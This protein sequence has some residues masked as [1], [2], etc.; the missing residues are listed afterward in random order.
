MHASPVSNSAT[1][2]SSKV[3]CG[4]TNGRDAR[5]VRS[6]M[7]YVLRAKHFKYNSYTKAEVVDHYIEMHNAAGPKE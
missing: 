2:S 6:A 5:F 3:C 4:G 7:E 1:T